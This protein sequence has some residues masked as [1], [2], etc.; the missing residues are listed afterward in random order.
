MSHGMEPEGE[1]GTGSGCRQR[2]QGWGGKVPCSYVS[3]SLA[4][5]CQLHSRG[6]D[7]TVDN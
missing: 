5:R 7:Q 2:A 3:S 4:W 1:L 6:N